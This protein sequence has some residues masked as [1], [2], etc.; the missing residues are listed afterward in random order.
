MSAETEGRG[1]NETS[2]LHWL[3]PFRLEVSSAPLYLYLY[4]EG[5]RSGIQPEPMS[6]IISIVRDEDF[7]QQSVADSHECGRFT[8]R[9]PA[10]LT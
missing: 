8:G 5:L 1:A 2:E 6:K 7:T 4:G 10:I 9:S 3:A